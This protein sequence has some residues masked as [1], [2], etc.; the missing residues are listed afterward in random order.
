MR[1]T[2]WLQLILIVNVFII[3]LLTPFVVRYARAHFGHA[4]DEDEQPPPKP[5]EHLSTV[6]RDHTL[7]HSQERFQT[8]I[9]HSAA[10]LQQELDATATQVNDLVKHL[11]TEIISSELERYRGDLTQLRK[12]AGVDMDGIRTEISK[13]TDELK[14]KLAEE[15]TIEK[16]QLLQQIDTKLGDAVAS[17]LLEALGHN[18]DLGNQAA[19]LTALLEEHKADFIKEVADEDKAS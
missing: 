5:A 4:K 12:Q 18:V 7:K 2:I 17:F 6:V 8:A 15:M 3:G 14:A 19:Y 10:V 16:K 1:D 9:N 11:A 13:H